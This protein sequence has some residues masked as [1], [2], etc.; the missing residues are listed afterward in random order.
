MISIRISLI[1]VFIFILVLA[2]FFH[3]IFIVI[4]FLF[5]FFLYPLIFFKNP[6]LTQISFYFI[7]SAVVVLLS[8]G[9]EVNLIVLCDGLKV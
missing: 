5:T 2:F 4:L 1:F 3:F 8:N 7:L 6:S 9:R